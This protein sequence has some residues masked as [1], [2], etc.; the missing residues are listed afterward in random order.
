MINK[1]TLANVD[2]YRFGSFKANIY[3]PETQ[4]RRKEKKMKQKK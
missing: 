3:L 4:E 2:S 1:Q